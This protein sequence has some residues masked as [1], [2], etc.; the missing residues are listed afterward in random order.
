MWYTTF[1]PPILAQSPWNLV[2]SS[3][4]REL[5]NLARVVKEKIVG[6]GASLIELI[7]FSLAPG[8]IQVRCFQ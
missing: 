3:R 4:A 8:F 1:L 2:S 6:G 7:Q 5:E